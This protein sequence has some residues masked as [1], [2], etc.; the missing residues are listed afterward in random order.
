MTLAD[1]NIS[2][3]SSITFHIPAQMKDIRMLG[4]SVQSLFA[5]LG[6]SALEACQLELALTEAANNI[7]KYGGLGN[8]T[9]RIW[10]KLVVKDNNVICI[11]ID[12]GNPVEFLLKNS[13]SDICTNT[14]TFPV[15]KRGPCV[16]N[17]IM[18]T[19][20]YARVNGKNVLTLIK[21]LP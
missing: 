13:E 18:D 6:F 19:V 9:D 11:F 20:N 21:H 16:I 10:V 1:S 17:K 3:G 7:V 15:S 8:V 12:Q 4:L 14:A 2:S 5:N